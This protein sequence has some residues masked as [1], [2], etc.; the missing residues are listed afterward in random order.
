MYSIEFSR[1]WY[2]SW[3]HSTLRL[4]F[5]AKLNIHINREI[6][7]SKPILSAFDNNGIGS[8]AQSGCC[9]RQRGVKSQKKRK[10]T[11]KSRQEEERTLDDNPKRRCETLECKLGI[12]VERGRCTERGYTYRSLGPI[13]I[14]VWR[15]WVEIPWQGRKF[16]RRS[17]PLV[18]VILREACFTGITTAKK[19][20]EKLVATRPPA[21]RLPYIF[22]LAWEPGRLWSSNPLYID[23]VYKA[24]S[25]QFLPLTFPPSSF[26][27]RNLKKHVY[28]SSYPFSSI[29]DASFFCRVRF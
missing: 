12:Q 19:K 11:K 18:P 25:L 3:F 21:Y 9:L 13:K 7:Y 4:V 22:E 14:A 15:S 26:T 28:I 10:D 6:V 29:E 2:R 8:V 5:K 17:F 16:L 27:K 1:S 23:R 24:L 20:L